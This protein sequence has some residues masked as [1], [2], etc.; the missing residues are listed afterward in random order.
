MERRHPHIFG[1]GAT[2]DVR[3][4]WEQIK[5]AERASDGPQGALASVAL[6]LPALLRAQKLQGRAAR[7]GFDWPDAEGPR[8]QI[9]TEERRGGKGWVSTCR[10]RWSPAP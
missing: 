8:A 9:R 1:G 10:Y 3:R 5:A 7:V 6:S 2:G 4:Q